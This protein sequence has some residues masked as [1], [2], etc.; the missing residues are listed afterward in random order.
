MNKIFL[1]CIDNDA[2]FIAIIGFVVTVICCLGLYKVNCTPVYNEVLPGYYLNEMTN[3]DGVLMGKRIEQPF[4][5]P[6]ELVKEIYIKI[7]GQYYRGGDEIEVMLLDKESKNIAKVNVGIGKIANDGWLCVPFKKL[8]IEKNKEYSLILS[9]LSNDSGG[10]IRLYGTKQNTS[11]EGYVK[12]DGKVTKEHLVF[13]IRG[14]DISKWW[15]KATVLFCLILF[16][17][18]IK[19]KKFLDRKQDEYV[20][21]KL[22]LMSLFLIYVVLMANYAGSG[23]FTDEFD[24]IRGGFVIAN[25]GVLYRDYVVQ[26]T[27]LMYYLCG[28]FAWVGAG[29]LQEFRLSYYAFEG[30]IWLAVF[31][32]YYKIFSKKK[33]F[34][35]CISMA[36]LLP[37]LVKH[38]GHMILSDRLQGL[39]L[40]VL[41]L[42]WLRLQY[43]KVIDW[44]SACVIA[45]CF[46]VS[47][48]VAFVSVYS[49]I[50]FVL[51]VVI[52][53]LWMI[54]SRRLTFVLAFCGAIKIFIVLFVILL[55][56]GG[57]FYFNNAIFDFWNQS[58]IF[59]R[60][61]YSK[62]LGG[63]GTNVWTPFITGFLNIESAFVNCFIKGKVLDDEV[64][65]LSVLLVPCVLFL[66]YMIAKK[67]I[68]YLLFLCFIAGGATRG[69]GFHGMAAWSV[70]VLVIVLLT[71]QI[72]CRNK[73]IGSFC[74][75]IG[76]FS[77]SRKITDKNVVGC[78]LILILV[79][80]CSRAIDHSQMKI[81]EK[82]MDVSSWEAYVASEVKPG[83]SIGYDCFPMES[84]YLHYKK[85]FPVNIGVY[86]LPWY[87]EW[88]ESDNLN[89]VKKEL[90]KI[91]VFD[92]NVS[93]WGY[94]HFM[95][96]FPEFLN[97][98]YKKIGNSGW[99]SC[100]WQLK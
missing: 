84:L 42:E 15:G 13:K 80:A 8:K 62:Y 2:I 91:V 94:S 26:H 99:M 33:M 75:K 68:E 20:D 61:V 88:F 14:G 83:K 10:G 89:A 11:F 59:N 36:L 69:L 52:F 38:V 3:E 96:E 31:A 73:T 79:S 93:V 50:W 71:D 82:T 43:N 45:V 1:K 32:R 21:I 78:A 57:Y 86:M 7:D 27:P 29:N 87:M 55:L 67:R 48:G 98:N 28:L 76:S 46:S 39:M 5:S 100:V 51:A 41:S 81:F 54:A 56:A 72:C 35:L 40:V 66:L 63:F 9:L 34:L 53:Q 58:Y 70:V 37:V 30:A 4:L 49:L 12:I 18:I 16:F 92:E 65:R 6:F 17:T 24:N 97:N 77:L 19:F 23:I 44:G 64:G 22:C 95:G 47:I 60:E 85:I 25:G 74:V 90:P